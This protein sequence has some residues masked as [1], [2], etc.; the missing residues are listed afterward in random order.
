MHK[1]PNLSL[2]PGKFA[3][4]RLPAEAPYPEWLEAGSLVAVI[5]STE[6]LSIVC[7]EAF[8]PPSVRSEA[9]WRCFEVQGP[10][11]FSLVGILASIA[12]PLAEAGVSIFA[13]STFDTD[14]ILVKEVQLEA[15]TQALTQ[16][17][18]M[19]ITDDGLFA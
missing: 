2:L 4:C 11:D 1:K 3:V 15:A 18:F 19:V 13:L 12:G 16:A 17:G 5:R 14:Y 7:Q 8:V 9:G 10:L 6:A